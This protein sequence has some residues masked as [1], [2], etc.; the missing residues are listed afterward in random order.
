DTSDGSVGRRARVLADRIV[1]A[2]MDAYSYGV[3]LQ[4][5]LAATRERFWELT[6]DNHRA[7]GDALGESGRPR[8]AVRTRSADHVRAEEFHL[9]AVAESEEAGVA[10]TRAL[11]R[12]RREAG[13]ARAPPATGPFPR[14]IG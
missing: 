1:A 13:R 2:A 7:I 5:D 3:D 9:A 4:E 6:R 10:Q 8:R 11:A 14:G 12:G